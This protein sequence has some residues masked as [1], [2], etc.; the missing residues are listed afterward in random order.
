MLAAAVKLVTLWVSACERRI[1]KQSVLGIA[2][3]ELIFAIA[4]PKILPMAL[5]ILF[6]ITDGFTIL[7]NWASQHISNSFF[8]PSFL[9]CA[10]LGGESSRQIQL[11]LFRNVFWEAF[12]FQR[13]RVQV[14]KSLCEWREIWNFYLA[15]T[16]QLVV[17][18]VNGEATKSAQV[19]RL[20]RAFCC[21]LNILLVQTVLVACLIFRTQVYSM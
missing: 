10:V 9:F 3:L 8:L 5:V 2:E 7:L 17:D 12:L 21:L 6:V 1:Q 15:F 16:N 13:I 20:F 4:V 19:M 11:C 14:L 18:T